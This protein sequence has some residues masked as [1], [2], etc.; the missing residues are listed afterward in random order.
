LEVTTFRR[1]GR[2]RDRR[3]P[4]TV[5]YSASI[6]DDLARRDFTISAMA[7]DLQ[8]HLLDPYGGLRDVTDGRIVS[9]GEA[10]DRFREDP[11]RML[12]AVRFVGL[13]SP[14]GSSFRL[15]RALDDAIRSMKFL[16]IEISAE[17]QRA[18][19][20]ALLSY[21]HFADALRALNTSGLLGVMW[22]EWV[23]VQD[24]DQHHPR[25]PFRL[26][27][28]SIRT[29]EAGP[30]VT[31]RLAGLL[32]DIAKPSCFWQDGHK[33]GHFYGHDRVGSVY[34][35]EILRRMTWDRPTIER[36]AWLIKYHLYP[37]E[38][39]GDKALRR[40]IREGGLERVQ[41]LITLRTM[42]VRGVG[43]DWEARGAVAERISLL[44]EHLV[45]TT[46]PLALTGWDVMAITGSGP[47]P[48]VGLWLKKLQD[49][50]DD[51]PQDNQHDI[52]TQK[53]REWMRRSP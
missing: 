44:G 12:R 10:R 49:F 33:A 52:L 27:E 42:D 1:E 19:L 16:L 8:G 48:Q 21:P 20:E 13:E 31:L 37:L 35:T 53:L 18:E 11:L 28:H 2:Y 4:Q 41:D 36:V 30:T 50:V 26:D 29:A 47:G 24:F 51:N 43:E 23:S 45:G 14:S 15:A 22:P 17:R 25:H 3:H 39:A 7:L 46:V 5:T 6:E 40:L 38:T 34:A 32:H 9:V